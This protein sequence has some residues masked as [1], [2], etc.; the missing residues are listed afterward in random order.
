MNELFDFMRDRVFHADD[1]APDKSPALRFEGF[2][3]SSESQL[4]PMKH[5]SWAWSDGDPKQI[6]TIMAEAPLRNYRIRKLKL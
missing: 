1:S 5:R 4:D 3:P 2:S 6:A